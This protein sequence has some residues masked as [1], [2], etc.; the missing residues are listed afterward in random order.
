MRSVKFWMSMG[1]VGLVVGGAARPAPAVAGSLRIPDSGTANLGTSI[2]E[3]A[4]VGDG[5]YVASIVGGGDATVLIDTASQA[6]TA[7]TAC[8]S[9]TTTAIAGGSDSRLYVG[10]SDGSLLAYDV[11]RNGLT[12]VGTTLDL[13]AGEVTALAIH[14]S[15]LYA[16]VQL[17]QGQAQYQTVD[18]SGTPKVSST[19]DTRIQS[20]GEV[21]RAVSSTNGLLVT[22]AMGVERL[23]PSGALLGSTQGYTDALVAGTQ[24]I[25]VGDDGKLWQYNG[26]TTS[27]LPV[28]SLSGIDSNASALGTLGSYSVVGTT[29]QELRLYTVSSTGLPSTFDRTL[30]PPSSAAFGDPIDFI[31]GQGFSVAGTSEGFLWFVTDGPWV[32]V[33][34]PDVEVSGGSGTAFSITFS[35]DTAGTAEVLLNGSSDTTGTVLVADLA[36]TADTPQ[37]LDF[38]L[39]DRFAEGVN[40]LRVVVQD[41]A[42]DRGRDIAYATLD[43]PPGQVSFNR[44]SENDDHPYVAVGNERL[45]VS[46]D[47]LPD[48]DIAHYVLFFS[49]TEFSR[50]QFASCDAVDSGADSGMLTP[51]V[52][53]AAGYC[54][55]EFENDKGAVSPIVLSVTGNSAYTVDLE[56]LDNGTEY[57]IAVRAYDEGGKEGA[58]SVVLNGTPQ[59]GVG[60]AEL[61][62]EQGGI[63]CGAGASAGWLG[64]ALASLALVGRRRRTWMVAPAAAMALVVAAPA[65]AKD[66]DVARSERKGNFQFRYGLFDMDDPNINKV[67]G[68]TPNEVLWLEVGPHLL[69]QVEVTAGMGWFQEIGN[70]VLS[71]GGTSD[72]NVMITALPFNL[73]LNL[74]ADFAK[75]QVIV[76]AVGASF[77]VWPWKQEP[78][79]GS[80]KISGMKTGWSWNAG[81]QLLL[82]RVDPRAASKLRVRTGI[83]D[84]YLTISYRAQEIGNASEGLVYSGSVIGFGLKLDY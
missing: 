25:V 39:D 13:G 28:F 31:E 78:Y 72:D 36:V 12:Q 67:M 41:A 81:V 77:E 50:D 4:S 74:R 52:A 53:T 8:G 29:N 27:A 58:M 45:S 84:T 83:E 5:R 17:D 55:P 62:G 79:R 59:Y 23:A 82:D 51:A 49:T 1:V 7:V 32:E 68:D 11:D 2:L 54:G 16:F 30:R 34:D 73:N 24:F 80:S 63:Q 18:V 6:S 44:V 61:S 75:N 46:F 69:P 14:N 15:L 47:A 43:D 40:E 57:W 66:P 3:M 22:T 60:P 10:C 33:A 65:H 71:S 70:A 76:P 64:V 19:G 48:P 38:T 35:S 56:S 21:R 9:A 26:S 42:G 37:T 20:I